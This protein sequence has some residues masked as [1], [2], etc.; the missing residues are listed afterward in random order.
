M[1]RLVKPI[2][3]PAIVG[4]GLLAVAHGFV[5]QPLYQWVLYGAGAAF[6]GIAA[7]VITAMVTGWTV[8]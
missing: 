1:L 2:V 7:W 8:H 3:L 6:L 5:S 4:F